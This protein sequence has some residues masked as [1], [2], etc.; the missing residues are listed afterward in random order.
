MSKVRQV[1]LEALEGVFRMHDSAGPLSRNSSMKLVRFASPYDLANGYSVDD[2]LVLDIVP[3][4]I[5]A[6][7]LYSLANIRFFFSVDLSDIFLRGSCYHPYLFSG[8]YKQKDTFQK[9][10]TYSKDV[11]LER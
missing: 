7:Q 9:W 1:D 8:P 6:H 4:Y 5:G 10:Q 2:I 3:Q 11:E